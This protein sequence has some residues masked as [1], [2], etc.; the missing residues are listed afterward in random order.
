MYLF[1]K[2]F[3]DVVFSF[4]ALLLLLPVFVIIII[5]L[6]FTGEKEVFYL[7]CRI[8]L[9]NKSFKIWKFATMLKNSPSIGTG[10]LTLRNDP[11]VTKLGKY[12]RITKINELPQIVNILKGDMSIVGPRPLMPKD[13]ERYPEE[14]KDKIYKVKP[15]LTGIGSIVFRDE[16]ALVSN[17]KEDPIFFYKNTIMPYKGA[18]EMWYQKNQSILL[19]FQIIFITAWLVI[20]PKS[21]TIDGVFKNLPKRTF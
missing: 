6:S 19:D 3:F 16:E 21:K 18:L 17:T 9:N 7:Q 2:R 8:G 20:S 15:G 11:R 10:T 12:L 13:V 5:L 1:F 4:I 14:I